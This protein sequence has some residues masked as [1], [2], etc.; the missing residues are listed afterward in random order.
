[1]RALGGIW[2]VLAAVLFGGCR[3]AEPEE[4]PAARRSFEDDAAAVESAL[5]AD[6]EPAGESVESA[7]EGWQD[8][9]DAPSDAEREERANEMMERTRQAAEAT[10]PPG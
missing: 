8:V 9:R 3:A 10:P 7:R 2:V 1:M 4:A 5:E 6:A